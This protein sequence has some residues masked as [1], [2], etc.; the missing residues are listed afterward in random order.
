MT[1]IWNSSVSR[2]LEPTSVLHAIK[3]VFPAF[4]GFQQHDSQVVNFMCIFYY[5]IHLFY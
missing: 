4:R 2:S 5:I 1:K 3:S